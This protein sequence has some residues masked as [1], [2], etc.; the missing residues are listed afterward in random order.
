[1]SAD[2]NRQTRFCVFNTVMHPHSKDSY[3]DLIDFCVKEKLTGRV[4]EGKILRI[5]S[6]SPYFRDKNLIVGFIYQY[7]DIDFR[8]NWFNTRSD[9]IASDEEVSQISIPDYLKPNLRAWRYAFSISDHK[10][11]IEVVDDDGRTV[12]AY[13]LKK[14]LINL[15]SRNEISERFGS[16]DVTMVPTEESVSKALSLPNLQKLTIFTKVPNPDDG[17]AAERRVKERLQKMKARSNKSVV[18]AQKRKE[19]LEPDAEL[20]EAA[21]IAALNGY[22]KAEGRDQRGA[23][24]SF[25]TEKHP[26]IIAATYDSVSESAYD[27]ISMI[28]KQKG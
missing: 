20:R 9:D 12:S 6:E 10:F 5:W 19:G 1:M 2:G 15:F 18:T 24:V 16:V 28:T 3:V 27:V 21:R 25:S 22:V 23:K 13:N 7:G 17:A 26:K 8:D 4:S 14:G 11:Y